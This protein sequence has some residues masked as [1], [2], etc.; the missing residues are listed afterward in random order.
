[1]HGLAIFLGDRFQLVLR[2]A[3]Q[4]GFRQ[5]IQWLKRVILKL[6][7]RATGFFGDSI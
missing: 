7:A 6:V 4:R 2:M 3:R 5:I 1:M